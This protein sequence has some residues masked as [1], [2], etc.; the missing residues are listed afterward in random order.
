MLSSMLKDY[1]VAIF[2]KRSVIKSVAA[3]LVAYIG[4]MATWLLPLPPDVRAIKL[5]HPAP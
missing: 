2:A 3:S 1:V 4:S 5:F